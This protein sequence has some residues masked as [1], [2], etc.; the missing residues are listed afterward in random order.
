M[1]IHT[2]EKPFV[3]L[4][5]GC[6]AKFANQA[7]LRYH[8]LKHK[9]KKSY[10][11]GFPDCGRCFLTLSQV[12]QH[13]QSQMHTSRPQSLDGTEPLPQQVDLDLEFGIDTTLKKQKTEEF[14]TLPI[15]LALS[16]SESM[17]WLDR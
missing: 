8:Q 7:G 5:R 12:R 17:D 11:C 10:R 1:R 3:C 15:S 14:V 6:E 13:E 16:L 4:E 9:N 2:G